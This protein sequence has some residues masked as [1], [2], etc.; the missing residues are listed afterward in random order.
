MYLY[1]TLGMDARAHNKKKIL[2]QQNFAGAL[3]LVCAAATLCHTLDNKKKLVHADA[4]IN[5]TWFSLY[6]VC[7]CVLLEYAL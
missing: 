5:S 3:A 2:C 7:V 6:G 1:M 4:D